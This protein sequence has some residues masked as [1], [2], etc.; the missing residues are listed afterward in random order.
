MSELRPAA[1]VIAAVRNHLSP[2]AWGLGDLPGCCG[3][4]GT[5]ST[6]FAA[7]AP[8]A[9]ATDRPTKREMATAITT[10]GRKEK[11][12]KLCVTAGQHEPRSDS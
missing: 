4:L 11:S 8:A 12:Q 1:W 6:F 9:K 2:D 10:S 5:P 3:G 7:A